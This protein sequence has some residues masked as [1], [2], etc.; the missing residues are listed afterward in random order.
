MVTP[1]KRCVSRNINALKVLLRAA[2]TPRKRCVSRN[3]S[4]CKSISCSRVTPRKRCV[5]RND[6][7]VIGFNI[8][9]SYTS[10]EVCE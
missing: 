9:F 2:V 5:S 7:A 8:N 3:M 10:Q 1:R 4:Y 6:F